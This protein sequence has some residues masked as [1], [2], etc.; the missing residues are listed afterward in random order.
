MG[1]RILT[2]LQPLV[3]HVQSLAIRLLRGTTLGVRVVVSDGKTVLL[4]R[5]TYVPGW[6]FP[7][8]GVNPGETVLEAVGRELREE[9]GRALTGPPRLH[10]IFFNR[11]MARRD[12]VLLYRA[13]AWHEA[14]A[15][16][17]NHEIAEAR[18]FPLDALPATITTATRARLAE[19][20]DGAEPSSDW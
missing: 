1:D 12:H 3:L 6:Y 8:G 17:P 15:F 7:G 18:F 4:V 20:F 9:T 2:V 19:L 16:V 14:S 13:D 11:Q 10:G 5:H